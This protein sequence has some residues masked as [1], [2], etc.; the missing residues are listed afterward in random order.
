MDLLKDL[1]IL[2]TFLVV[3]HDLVVADT[4]AGVAVLEEPV[5]VVA[6]A[7]AGLHGHPPEVEVISRAIVGRL[8]F[9]SG[10]LGKVGP[11]LDAACREVV[12]PE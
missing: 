5:G 7:L 11:Q 9:Q 1:A 8:E 10:G 6:K 4:N 12:E 2:N 3:V